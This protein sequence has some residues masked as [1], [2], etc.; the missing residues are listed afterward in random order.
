MILGGDML[1]AAS[2]GEGDAGHACGSGVRLVQTHI[3][4]CS[5]ATAQTDIKRYRKI[6][7]SWQ[8]STIE[9]A[10]IAGW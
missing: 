8:P 3:T 2:A 6:Y 4:A 7:D 10:G 5:I 9:T 1:I